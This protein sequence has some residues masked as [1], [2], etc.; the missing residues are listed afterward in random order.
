[1]F[2][3]FFFLNLNIQIKERLVPALF[4]GRAPGERAR[5]RLLGLVGERGWDQNNLGLIRKEVSLDLP[6]F[7]LKWRELIRID[8]NKISPSLGFPWWFSGGESTCQ[9]RGNRFYPSSGKIPRAMEQLSP[10][11]MT[12]EPVLCR[13]RGSCREK[14]LLPTTRETW[15]QQQRRSTPK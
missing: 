10:S 14:P 1:M 8:M 9:C 7:S 12:A 4:T 6:N 3:L 11:A 13:E 15:V 5:P 2:I